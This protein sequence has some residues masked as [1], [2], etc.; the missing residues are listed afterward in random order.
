VFQ[1]F[2]GTDTGSAVFINL[3]RLA[4]VFLLEIGVEIFF[5][6]ET[7]QKLAAYAGYLAR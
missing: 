5:K 6:I 3:Y 4:D 2:W 1:G 7:A